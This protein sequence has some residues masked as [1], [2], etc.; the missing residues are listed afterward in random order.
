[1]RSDRRRDNL[2]EERGEP[3]ARKD[4]IRSAN[5]IENTAHLLHLVEAI[6]ARNRCE[7]TMRAE[8]AMGR[9]E[10][11]DWSWALLLPPPL[12]PEDLPASTARETLQ[13]K[14]TTHAKHESISILPVFHFCLKLFL[15]AVNNL[16]VQ[17]QTLF[18]D[19]H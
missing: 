9:A 16:L 8:R 11:L 2:G 13:T 7:A 4:E 15:T 5:Q 17:F 10:T 1:M 14:S 3:V 12:S 6:G 19:T 18:P